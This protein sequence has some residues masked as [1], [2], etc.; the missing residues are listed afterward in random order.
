ML[1]Y[2][3]TKFYKRSVKIP[4]FGVPDFIEVKPKYLD[5]SP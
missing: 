2:K 4:K 3:R 5:L 1:D